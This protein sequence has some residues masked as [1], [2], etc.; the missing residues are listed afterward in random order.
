MKSK[1]VEF[2]YNS[3]HY[4]QHRFRLTS[5]LHNSRN[6]AEQDG[7][8]SSR[9]VSKLVERLRHA[10]HVANELQASAQVFGEEADKQ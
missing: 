4:A 7:H 2:T 8:N 9:S 5:Y 6:Q 1:L 10:E 3:T